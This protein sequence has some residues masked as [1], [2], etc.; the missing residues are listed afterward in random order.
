VGLFA[1]FQCGMLRLKCHV[2][3]ALDMVGGQCAALYPEKPIYDIPGHPAI[4]GAALIAR[5]QEQAAPFNPVLHLGQ[6]VQGLSALPDG[7]GWL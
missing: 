2:I 5:L 6:Q 4:D 7:T 3:D 1:I